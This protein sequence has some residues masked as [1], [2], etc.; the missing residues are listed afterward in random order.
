MMS[1]I[2]DVKPLVR[3]LVPWLIKIRR[4]LHMYPEHSTEEKETQRKVI[5]YLEEMGIPY[6]TFPDHYGVLG[7]LQGAHPGKTVA[8]R[9]DMDALP[10]EDLKETAYRS[11]VKGVCHACGH[12][13]HTTILL[14]AA[15][16]L[17]QLTPALKGSIKLIFQPAE[18]TIG[19]ALP[20][21]Q[22]G[23]LENPKVDAIFGLHVSPEIPVGKIGIKYD[24]MNGASD[25]V[26]ITIQGKSTHGAYPQNG[27]DAIVIAAQTI[28]MLQTLVSRNVDPRE[29]AVLTLGLIQGGTQ[30]NI[31]AQKVIIKGTLRTVDPAIRNNSHR[32]IEEVV[33]HT[34]KALGGT[35]SVTITKGYSPLINNDAMVE[36]VRKNAGALLGEAQI[37]VLKKVSLGVE[38]FA[39]FLEAVPGAFYRLGSGNPQRGIIHPAHSG[40][41]DIDEDCLEIGVLLQV[42]NVLE[43]LK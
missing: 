14:G 35:G 9:A 29:A 31:V 25:E 23:V 19:G 40:Y 39:F 8:L 5:S 24:Q 26:A 17:K 38:D 7:I 37:E 10:L 3:A 43:S 1:E 41:F 20:M 6:Q 36:V 22:Q 16:I 12:D 15:R 34:T 13:A 18:E 21:I 28:S 4:D 32:R 30:E 33:E 11:Q 42:A 27:V 2:K